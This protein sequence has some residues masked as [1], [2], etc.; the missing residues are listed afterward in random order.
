M[1]CFSPRLVAALLMLSVCACKKQSITPSAEPSL[2]LHGKGA[3]PMFF[4]SKPIPIKGSGGPSSKRGF[5]TAPKTPASN[6]AERPSAIMVRAITSNMV[7]SIAGG[8]TKIFF[9]RLQPGKYHVVKLHRDSYA[10]EV[11][12]NA[13]V[14]ELLE[15][16]EVERWPQNV[17]EYLQREDFDPQSV[18]GTSFNEYHAGSPTQNDKNT[19][20]IA[21]F[22][23]AGAASSYGSTTMLEGS[24]YGSTPA[25]SGEYIFDLEFE[26]IYEG[27]P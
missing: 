26:S 5:A 10:E 27:K 6:L 21:H 1:N 17:R 14:R 2:S 19:Y 12:L 23:E 24:T 8:R 15:I 4:K 16:A 22:M 11:L 20:S 25:S 18:V 9:Q 13:S 7:T 3:A